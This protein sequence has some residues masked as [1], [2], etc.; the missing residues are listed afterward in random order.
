MIVMEETKQ[1]EFSLSWLIVSTRH[2]ICEYE[3]FLD[4]R[5][6][7]SYGILKD[8]ITGCRTKNPMEH[9]RHLNN[10]ESYFEE[11][12]LMPELHKLDIEDAAA[13]LRRWCDDNQIRYKEDLEQYKR[14]EARY[15]GYEEDI[16][17]A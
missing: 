16:I 5:N 8:E 12:V 17:A 15:W 9:Y 6:Y 7:C 4:K 14:I 3:W 11:C 1:K 10:S 2:Y 13:F